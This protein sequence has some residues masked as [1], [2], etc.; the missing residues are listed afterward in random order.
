M[1]SLI[2][3]WGFGGAPLGLSD[4]DHPRFSIRGD[5]LR[6]YREGFFRPAPGAGQASINASE[7]TA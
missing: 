4:I 6:C 2:V 5:S 3:R 7:V 1:S